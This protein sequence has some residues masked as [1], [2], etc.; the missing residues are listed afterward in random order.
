MKKS[1]FTVFL[2]IISVLVLNAQALQGT[3]KHGSK[4]EEVYLTIRN[5]S[6]TKIAGNITKLQFTLR[7]YLQS[8]REKNVFG[9]TSL[10]FFLR[11][12][13]VPIPALTS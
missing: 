4:E 13:L 1:L 3:L 12:V 6:S 9:S 10:I 8:S 11:R 7:M 5:N 2:T